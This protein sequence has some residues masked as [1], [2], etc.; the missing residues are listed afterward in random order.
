MAFDMQDGGGDP[1]PP[2]C[3]KCSMICT[4]VKTGIVFI[5][6][7]YDENGKTCNGCYEE[8]WFWGCESCK[9]RIEM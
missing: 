7:H 3:P 2:V 4:K 6:F 9:I 5:V 8:F 1:G